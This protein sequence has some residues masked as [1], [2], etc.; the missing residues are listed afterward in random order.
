MN[1]VYT[2]NNNFVPQVAAGICS[3]CENNRN[4]KITF[5]LIADDLSPENHQKLK[6]F[7]KSYHQDVKIIEIGDIR[8]HFDFDFDA[9]GWNPVVVTRLLLDKFLPST[10]DRV[11]YLDGDTI[12]RGNLS[13]LYQ[14]DMGR[15]VIGA[16]AEPT[17]D[18][19]R[20]NTLVGP[21]NLYYNSGVLLIN[22]KKWRKEHTGKKI[23]EY[24]RARDGKLF[25]PDQDAINGA[26]AGEI[27]TLA[28][29]YNFFNIYTQY[30]YQ[31]LRKMVQPAEYFS[32]K[33]FAESVKNPIII[34]YLGEER[35]WRVGSTHKY[36]DD[37][38]KYLEKTPWHN[39]P[40]E[41]G[42]R[43][44]F[45][46]WKIF[47]TITKP[48]PALRYRIITS[49]IPLFIKLRTKQ[50]HKSEDLTQKEKD[51]E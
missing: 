38:K 3:I 51:E 20:K 13:E 48:F 15:S 2:F 6:D 4:E 31:F 44:Y 40:D 50:N 24:Y 10:V 22:M 17:V 43:V 27:Y 28:P 47:N 45:A 9:S 5:Y 1:I 18:R 21:K 46:C 39:T 30:P 23:L 42:W 36:R 41:E 29:K 35:P 7:V 16:G 19:A 14:T 32:A 11:L 37:Y 33:E 49:L 34:H 12:V 8:K 26:L 25:A